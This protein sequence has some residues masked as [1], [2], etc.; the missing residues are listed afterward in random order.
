MGRCSSSQA[1]SPSQ[2][3]SLLASRFDRS[4]EFAQIA[5]SSQQDE[6]AARVE[7]TADER[8]EAIEILQQP[9]GIARADG[10]EFIAARID[11]LS[12]FHPD[13]RPIAPAALAAEDP[14]AM[15]AAGAV[16]ERVIN[17]ED[18]LGV[19]YMEGGALAA[20]AVGRV[21]I[22]DE[23]GKLA[24]YGTGSLVSPRL[25]L[26]NHHVLPDR[27]TASFSSIEFDYED[28]LDGRPLLSKLFALAPDE[29]MIA[30]EELDFALVAVKATV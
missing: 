17:T 6:A 14:D 2:G 10:T 4:A 19:R 28:G 26:T 24:G 9:G 7:A 21:N 15:A 25:L 18:F 30:D 20:R 11:R 8:M 12:R 1:L 27:A 23:R 22:R 16:L 3:R 5:G 13:I 29:L